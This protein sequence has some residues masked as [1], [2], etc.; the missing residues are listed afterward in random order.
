MY[1]DGDNKLQIQ[2]VWLNCMCLVAS[3]QITKCAIR[4]VINYYR[5]IG[6][7]PPCSG[8]SSNNSYTVKI[9]GVILIYF[10]TVECL[11]H[12]YLSD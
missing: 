2:F 12:F 5:G 6:I 11:S 4:I 8:S 7:G 1:V 9:D 10:G 3:T